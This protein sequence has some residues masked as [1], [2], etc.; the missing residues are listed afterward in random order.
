MIATRI[1]RTAAERHP[2]RV[3]ANSPIRVAR[4]ISGWAAFM[5][6]VLGWPMVPAAYS[7]LTTGANQY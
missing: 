2:L 4:H 6:T 5:V 1:L 7:R 3:G